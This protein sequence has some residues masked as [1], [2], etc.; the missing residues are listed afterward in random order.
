[1]NSIAII[2]PKESIYTNPSLIAL[3]EKL[4]KKKIR[5]FLIAP[6]QK[7]KIEGF[8]N[9][10][11]LKHFPPF[12]S[13]FPRR[14]LVMMRIMFSYLYTAYILKKN[15][16]KFILG[17]DPEGLIIAGRIN[18]MLHKILGY[19]SFEIIYR[20]E[21]SD[22]RYFRAMKKKE[23]SY[24]DKIDFLIIQDEEREN[25]L[26]RE[27]HISPARTKIFYVPV[28]PAINNFT[29]DPVIR[30]KLGIPEGKKV[31]LYSGS[32]GAWTGAND[33]LESVEKYW[34]DNF[35]LVI[36]SHS[37]FSEKSLIRAK[38]E[39]LVKNGFPLSMHNKPFE[40]YYD[41]S[42]F[43]SNF[44]VG[45]VF[46]K[47]D[48]KQNAYKGK[49][50][51]F[52]GLSSGKFSTFMMLGIPVIFNPVAYYKK[53]SEKYDFGVCVEKNIDFSAGLSE[54][55]TG[56]KKKS[57]QSRLLYNDLLDPDKTIP[58]L[59]NYFEKPVIANF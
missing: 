50:T 35:W 40:S 13:Q 9:I 26:L 18:R 24:S 55:W 7:A 45:F 33:I 36:H 29:R 11:H 12:F 10:S 57:E 15:K 19:L 23:L 28:S 27:N 3:F 54:L 42:S 6:E 51:E 46:Y 43:V 25:L 37:E 59:I 14:P 39:S 21:I 22:D 2:T 38:I 53:L 16:I 8:E 49:N 1:M 34:N 58:P 41:Y 32:I 56:Y 5:V 47:P 30:K 44:D 20:D 48:V 31:I 4:K 17:I 52:I